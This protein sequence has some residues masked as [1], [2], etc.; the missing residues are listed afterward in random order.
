MSVSYYN[1]DTG[2]LV[3]IAKGTLYADAPVGSIQAY[4]GTTAPLG[5][6]LCQG[7]AVSRTTYAELF[8]V[9]GTAFGTGDG[10]TTFNLP[11]LRESVPKGTGLTSNSNYHLNNNGGLNVG[12]FIDDRLQ[13][14]RHSI[15]N[16]FDGSSEGSAERGDG[17]HGNS[18][19]STLPEQYSAD[20][21]TPRIGSTTEVKAVGVNYIIKAKHTS[22]PVDFADSLVGY[23]GQETDYNLYPWSHVRTVDGAD[24]FENITIERDGWYS[25]DYTLSSSTDTNNSFTFRDTDS[26]GNVHTIMKSFYD[27]SGTFRQTFLV[28]LKAGNYIYSHGGIGTLS[29]YINRRDFA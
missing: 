24:T 14:H 6:L 16:G 4:G 18:I 26:Q 8:A 5:W 19:H 28:P 13:G 22:V 27:K 1:K 2:E 11:D 12:E 7:Q 15:P 20:Y 3:P 21:G 23:V 25:I 9:I 10:S 29:V 17:R